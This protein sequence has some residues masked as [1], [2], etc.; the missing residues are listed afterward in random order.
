MCN[1]METSITYIRGISAT[2][3]Y[4]RHQLKTLEQQRTCKC[5]TRPCLTSKFP[6]FVLTVKVTSISLCCSVAY[7]SAALTEVMTDGGEHQTSAQSCALLSASLLPTQNMLWI[8]RK[9][10]LLWL[11][12]IVSLKTHASNYIAAVTNWPV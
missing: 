10:R 11:L 5:N 6:C 2:E 9:T 1:Q 7:S 8:Y 4:H 12:I 3:R